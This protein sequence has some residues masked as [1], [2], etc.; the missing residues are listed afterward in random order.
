MFTQKLTDSPDPSRIREFQEKEKLTDI[1]INDARLA[2]YI[3][4]INNNKTP[5]PDNIYPREL[6]KLKNVLI[7]PL[8][9]CLMIP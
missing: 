5:G 4:N 3:N 2:K 7:N 6:K 1:N 8:T 9:R